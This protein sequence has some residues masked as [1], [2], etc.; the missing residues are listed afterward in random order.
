ME[1]A[2]H[3][4]APAQQMSH[5]AVV[6][7]PAI[8]QQDDTVHAAVPNPE[9]KAQFVGMLIAN[10]DGLAFVAFGRAPGWESFRSECRKGR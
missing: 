8:R 7:E 9:E 2:H 4:D 5:R 1:A 3:V 6:A 10:R